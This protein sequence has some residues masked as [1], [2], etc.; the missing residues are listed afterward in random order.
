LPASGEEPQVRKKNHPETENPS[1]NNG[2]QTLFGD[3]LILLQIRGLA[4]LD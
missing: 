3:K 1:Q 4:R 2:L